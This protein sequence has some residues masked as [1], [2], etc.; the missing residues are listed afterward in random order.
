MLR[1]K[2][3]YKKEGGL[4]IKMICAF[5][6]SRHQIQKE[7]KSVLCLKYR[8]DRCTCQLEGNS[9]KLPK[10]PELTV[11]LCYGDLH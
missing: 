5:P 4:T 8:T 1:V 6:V 3:R 7:V 10:V 2:E 9:Y 11:S